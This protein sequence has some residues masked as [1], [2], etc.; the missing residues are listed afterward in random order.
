M[1][2]FIGAVLGIIVG[3]VAF[4][5]NYYEQLLAVGRGSAGLLV[6]MQLNSAQNMYLFGGAILGAIIGLS[7]NSKQITSTQPRQD[8][9]F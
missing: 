5:A 9:T 6:M 3:F 8:P 4:F 2:A 1:K 7:C